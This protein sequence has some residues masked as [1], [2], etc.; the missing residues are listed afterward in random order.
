[1]QS[2]T[3]QA[4]RQQPSTTVADIILSAWSQL[5]PATREQAAELLCTR[6]T[7]VLRLL[8]AID[9][10]QLRLADISASGV[11]ALSSYPAEA[12]RKRVA[13]IRDQSAPADRRQ[14]FDDYR[15][16]LADVGDFQR[17]A[18]VFALHCAN[19]HQ[20]AGRGHAIGP[21][22]TAMASRGAE[23]LLYNILVPNGE[24]DPRYASYAVLTN[25]GRLRSGIIASESASSVTLKGSQ[26][27]TSTILRVDIDELRSTGVSMM[28]EGFERLVD[29][30]AMSD[31][32]AYLQSATTNED[33]GAR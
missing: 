6:E 33:K 23:A 29:K 7:W 8:E 31:L 12:I 27:E 5:T 17:G 21:N 28:P 30:P 26:D 11:M 15:Q 2:A 25:D 24:I 14:V 16:V 10:G 18:T 13:A 22:L 20:V 3:L 9:Q 4:L 19:C 1:L 32:L